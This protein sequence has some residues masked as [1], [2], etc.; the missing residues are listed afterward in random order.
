MCPRLE[1]GGCG[2]TRLTKCWGNGKRRLEENSETP[3]VLVA[4]FMVGALSNYRTSLK[5]HSHG[6]FEAK[7]KCHA[8]T[9]HCSPHQPTIS[10]VAMLAVSY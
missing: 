2:N 10:V 9:H 7:L 4:G 6:M 3:V 5:V 8:C 1:E